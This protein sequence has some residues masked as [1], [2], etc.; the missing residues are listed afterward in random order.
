V[1]SGGDVLVTF[2]PRPGEEAGVLAVQV[3]AVMAG[4]LVRVA[5]W[6]P[7]SA[8]SWPEVVRDAVVFAAG[9]LREMQDHGADVGLRDEG[10]VLAA[11][12]SAPTAFPSL[13]VRVSPAGYGGRQP[14]P[15]TFFAPDSI[16]PGRSRPDTGP[17]PA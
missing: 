15:A 7:V 6:D 10:D 2:A 1:T 13:P 3:L 12:G 4:L 9:A 17:G 16:L 5:A 8:G 14:A 11:A